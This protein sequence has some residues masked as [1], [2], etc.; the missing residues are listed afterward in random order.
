VTVRGRLA[1]A[2][3]TLGLLAALAGD[4]RPASGAVDPALLAAVERGEGRV[5]IVEVA[6]WLRA[7]RADLEIVDLR[8][9][10]A[11]ADFHLPGSVNRALADVA[12]LRPT[13]A[14][15]LVVYADPG[16]KAAQAWLVLRSLGHERVYY[17]E[18]GVGD[19]L[20]GIVSPVLPDSA[21]PAERAAWPAVTEL[22]R[23]YGG[24]PS[25]GGPRPP[26]ARLAWFEDPAGA[27]TD[28][29]EVH[30]ARRRGC[31]F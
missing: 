12:A 9:R 1:L 28:A 23:Y 16:P 29:G 25:R 21:S 18:R 7:Q 14:R 2:A 13:V 31:G 15:T 24:L 20:D 26:G 6:R 10:A 17:L 3:G 22:S 4:A 30:Q 5:G 8:T 19:W 11:Y 27:L